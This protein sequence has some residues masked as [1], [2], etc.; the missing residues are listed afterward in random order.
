MTIRSKRK[1]KKSKIHSKILHSRKQKRGKYNLVYMA[2]PPYGGWVS[3]TAH[4]AKKFNYDLFKIGNKTERNKRPYGYEVEY[5]NLSINDLV[6]KPNLLIT[7]IDNKYYHFLPSIKNAT[8]VIHDPTELKPEVLEIL[9]RF[10]VITIRETVHKLLKSKYGI[11]N[12]FLYHPFY[13]FPT[14]KLKVTKPTAISLSRID[15]D[16]HT[17]IILKA[18]KKLK[19]PIQIYG[20][21]NNMY[22][23]HKLRELNFKK[24][25]RGK[26]GKSFDAIND[27]LDDVKFVVDM[28]AI[29]G[30]GGG[31]QYTFLEAIYM[32]C[33][34]ILNKRWTEGVKT[35]FKHGVNCFIVENEDELATILNKNPNTRN[36]VKNARK[37]LAV[38]I[39][40]KGW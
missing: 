39:K 19:Y 22:I 1:D 27:L 40:A 21:A 16:K 33:A 10:K 14:K 28:S 4:L 15:F 31:S 5:Q 35:P 38:H 17:D 8:I 7:A 24:Y 30:D 18:N 20:A 29:K 2:K 32:N 11:N 34:L 36:I 6:K 12:K 25:Y 26:F 23:Y 3:F 9:K 13:E 37:L